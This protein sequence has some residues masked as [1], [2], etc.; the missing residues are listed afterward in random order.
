M[1]KRPSFYH[2]LHPP[3]IPA[4]EARFRYTFGLGG[5]SLFLFIILI[6]TGSLEMF[7]YIPSLEEANLSLQKMVLLVP[8]GQLIRSLHYW[9]AQ[10]LVITTTLHLLRIV[11]TGAYKPP[12]RFNWLLGL[13][14]LA[15]III[16]NFTGYALRWDMDIA[17]AI[18]VGTNLLKSVPFIGSWLYG[19][20]V[21]GAEIGQSTVVRLYSWHIYGLTLAAAFLAGWHLFRV[22]R[23]GGISRANSTKTVRLTISRN[24]LVR[25]ELLAMVVASILLLLIALLYPPALGSNADFNNLPAEASAPWFFLWVQQL[26]RYGSPFITGVFVPI[27]FLIILALLP[28]VVDR[29]PHGVGHW[30]NRQGRLAQIVTIIILGVILTFTIQNAIK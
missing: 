2:H 5:I 3:H 30:F 23:D 1:P 19:L 17:W 22:R 4:R 16:L 9:S 7:Y 12:R 21:G 29:S 15:L 11:F 20:V 6:I 26:L 13:A 10:A 27:L 14:L 28:Y 18:M 24:L 25:R 8:Y